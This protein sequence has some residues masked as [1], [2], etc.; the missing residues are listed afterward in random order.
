MAVRFATFALLATLLPASIPAGAEDHLVIVGFG[1]D[2]HPIYVFGPNDLTIHAGDTV[3]FRSNG[4]ARGPHNVHAD[5]GSFRCALGCDGEGGNGNPSLF[6]SVTRRFDHVGTIRYHCDE[7]A[8]LGERGVI[9]VVQG[10]GA[11]VNVPITSGFTGAWYDP[12]QAGHGIFIEIGSDGAQL[13]AWW[14]TFTPD[15]EQAWFG[16]VG[17]IDPETNTATVD[18]LQTQGGRWIPNFDPANLTN[19]VWGQLKFSFSDCNH[20]R[21]DFTSAMPGYGE[22]HMDVTRLT[23][24]AGLSCP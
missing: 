24:P 19:P 5:D 14:F 22:G 16:N 12:A 23:M 2:T 9:R 10:P 21:V 15:G 6:W 20:G 3:T 4:G 13:L 17:A 8:D 7:H 1:N 11:P 18:A